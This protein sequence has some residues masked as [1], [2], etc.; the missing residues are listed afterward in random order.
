M[1]PKT[2]NQRMVENFGA[3]LLAILVAKQMTRAELARKCGLSTDAI[4]K[5]ARGARVPNLTT[6]ASIAT[7]LGVSVTELLDGRPHVSND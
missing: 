2:E 3:R 5:L 6:A 1:K 4:M 7:A